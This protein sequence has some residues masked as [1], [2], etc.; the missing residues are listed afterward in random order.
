MFKLISGPR[1]FICDECVMLCAGV[2][3]RE[4]AADAG[5]PRPDETNGREKNDSQLARGF[6]GKPESQVETLIAGPTAYICDT[7]I[8]RCVDIIEEEIAAQNPPA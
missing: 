2:L 5:G 7:C 8:D 6:C 1:V 4:K 3:E